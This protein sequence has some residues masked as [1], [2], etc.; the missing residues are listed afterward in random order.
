MLI[1]LYSD[2]NYVLDGFKAEF[3]VT[4]CL[5]NCTYR[6]KCVE[7]KCV[8]QGDWVGDDCSKN[9]CPENCGLS[10]RRGLC[11]RD[12][13]YCNDGFSGQSC[14]LSAENPNGNE[15]HWLSNTKDGLSPRAAHTAFYV[16]KTDSL[17]IFGGYDLN[18][19]LGLLQIYD[20]S[21]SEW[22]NETGMKLRNRY[23]SRNV[24]KGL[25]R[26]VLHQNDDEA[27]L[28]GLKNRASLFHNIL[29]SISDENDNTSPRSSRSTTHAKTN[30]TKLNDKM[31]GPDP[32]YGHAGCTYESGFVIYGG[33]LE[34]GKLS[35]QL[36]LYN[37][38]DISRAWSLR[39]TNS[40][41]IPPSLTRHTITL[42]N[43]DY[44]YLFG[45]STEL[46]EFSSR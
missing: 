45:G 27:R 28:W 20:F 31:S 22:Q 38:T 39:A 29:I 5:N 37:I 40:T 12:H 17:Y 41:K 13:C 34:D 26:A 46:G 11:R 2:T 32:R 24:D 9:A 23:F 35:N 19:I 16:E 7:H 21:K 42:A 8:C 4:N 10:E 6:G 18:N 44:I 36:W 1:L 25:L 43:D 14:S 3:S 33:K 30:N 15:W